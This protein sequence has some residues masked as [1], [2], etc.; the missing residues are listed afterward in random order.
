[1]AIKLYTQSAFQMKPQKD[2]LLEVQK[3]DL[4]IFSDYLTL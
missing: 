4:Y 1:M 3:T 2:S